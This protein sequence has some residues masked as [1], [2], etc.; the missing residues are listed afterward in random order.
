LQFVATAAFVAASLIVTSHPLHESHV[1]HRRAADWLHANAE[2]LTAVL[3]QQGYTALY[4]GRT[5]YRFDAAENAFADSL[6][7]YTLVE[8][9]DLEADT[10]RG[11]SLRTVLGGAD[12]AVARFD[13]ERGRREH[14][15][16]IFTRR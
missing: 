11:A 4:T 15:V 7:A 1:Q 13:D 5:T 14:D 16:L 10:R 12:R 8:R 2:P 6:L 9:A 3:D